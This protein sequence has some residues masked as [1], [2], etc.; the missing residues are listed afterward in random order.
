MFAWLP[1]V[2]GFIFV[3]GIV[4]FVHEFGHFIV[5]RLNDVQVDAFALGMGPKLLSYRG[6]ETEYRLCIIPLGG[7]VEL[8]GEEPWA[9]TDN[10][11]A[12][13][14]KPV[15][16]RMTVLVAGVICNILLG[17]FIYVA[18]G[19]FAGEV[20][21]PARVGYVSENLP[22]YGKLEIGDEIVSIN[23]REVNRFREVQTVNAIL[24]ERTRKFEVLRDGQKK[25]VEIE[26]HYR[27]EAG[28]MASPYIVGIAPYQPPVIGQLEPEGKFANKNLA[29]GD[30]IATVSGQKVKS[31]PHFQ[32]L[33]QASA[34]TAIVRVFRNGEQFELALNPPS[35]EKKFKEWHQ[36]MGWKLG[37]KEPVIKSVE[38]GKEAEILGF[39]PGDTIVHAGDT[40]VKSGEQFREIISNAAGPMSV[41][42]K[43]NSESRKITI[44]PPV[45]GRLFGE[46]FGQL[47]G[48]PPVNY[49]YYN[50]VTVW[51][52]AYRQTREVIR[53]LFLAL[54]GLITGQLS[55]RAMAGPV[56]IVMVTGE[57]ARVGFTS[58]LGFTAFLSVNLGIINLLPIPVLD[59]GHVLMSLPELFT[60]RRLPEKAFE[61]AN[62]IGIVF[63]LS[64]MLL[65]TWVD[66]SRIGIFEYFFGLFGMS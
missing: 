59:G 7:Y 60:G 54:W 30:T 35:I 12:F 6:E 62:T 46:W 4:V 28:V 23:N 63:L 38:S 34:D 52:Y 41:S 40:P 10:P 29:A 31:W 42:I 56:G 55:P 16:R 13:A 14:N 5:A 18:L 20:V 32:Q 44:S 66:L 36:Q 64:L 17:F 47:G 15:L 26:P 39:R 57:I 11:R 3:F 21:M 53:L 50:L 49:K 45:A 61:I 2:L 25:I 48:G 8:A 58:L 43:R 1:T 19:I 51:N 27:E 33:L 65:V 37:E 9:E 24:G 22:A